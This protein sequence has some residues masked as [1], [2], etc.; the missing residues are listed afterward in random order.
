MSVVGP[1]PH[2]PEYNAYY[3]QV[4]GNQRM[5]ERHDIKPGLTGLAQIRGY[6]G[7]T[8]DKASIQNRINSDIEYIKRRSKLLDV[9][10][11]AISLTQT[12]ASKVQIIF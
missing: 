2:L 9:K 3:Q 6:R 4:V 8:P 10:I 7:E 11:I 5:V 1:R 12:D